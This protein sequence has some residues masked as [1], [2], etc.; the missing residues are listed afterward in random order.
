MGRLEY[1]VFQRNKTVTYTGTYC[2]YWN[3]T[4]W[5]AILDWDLLVFLYQTGT[6][7]FFAY[8]F[9]TCTGL[10]TTTFLIGIYNSLYWNGTY[11]FLDR[12]HGYFLFVPRSI[13]EWDLLLF[14]YLSKRSF[15]LFENTVL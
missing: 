15:H 4:Y 3:G 12:L 11:Y 8:S 5:F 10:E 1:V 7:F 9:L 13:L 6:F 14:I 2:L